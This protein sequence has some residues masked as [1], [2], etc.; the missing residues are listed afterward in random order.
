MRCLWLRLGARLR[1]RKTDVVL[2]MRATA[3]RGMQVKC[4]ACEAM[5]T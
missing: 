2:L 5:K 3:P 4:S 1:L